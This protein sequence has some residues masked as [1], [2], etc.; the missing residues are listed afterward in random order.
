VKE[1]NKEQDMVLNNHGSAGRYAEELR[2]DSISNYNQLDDIVSQY[3]NLYGGKDAD[4]RTQM[5]YSRE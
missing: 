5:S 3:S 4:P 2:G 1:Y